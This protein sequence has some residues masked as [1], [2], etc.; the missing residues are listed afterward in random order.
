VFGFL[1]RRVFIWYLRQTTIRDA[2]VMRLMR[3]PGV[4]VIP[5]FGCETAHG[6]RMIFGGDALGSARACV[7]GASDDWYC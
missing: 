4:L 6:V 7:H 5:D 3:L 2:G 1:A